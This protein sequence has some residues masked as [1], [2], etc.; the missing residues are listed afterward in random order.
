MEAGI[1]IYVRPSADRVM[2]NF[3]VPKDRLEQLMAALAAGHVSTR[4]VPMAL[5]LAVLPEWLTVQGEGHIRVQLTEIN[6]IES[7][8]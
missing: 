4:D 7:D 6:V 3:Y 1:E 5:E 2:L 8:T